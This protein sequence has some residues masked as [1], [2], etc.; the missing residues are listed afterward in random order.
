MSDS[1]N[2][3]DAALLDRFLRSVT[4]RDGHIETYRFLAQSGDYAVIAATLANPRLDVVIKLAGPAAALAC[5]FDRTTAMI[6][7]IRSRTAV[8]TFKV[9]AVD[10]S[11]TH[12]PWRYLVMTAV[13]GLPWFEA[14]R[15]ADAA[16][17]REVNAALGR[18][19]GRLHAPRFSCCGEIDPLGNIVEG[20]DYQAA[21][22]DRARRR[23]A[24]P[25]HL[26]I[27]V[28]L[29]EERAALFEEIA[30]GNICHEDL[31]PHNILVH[32]Y[33]DQG[34]T[35]ALVDFDSAWIGNAESDLARLEFWSGMVGEG[36][37][38]AYGAEA[39][40]DPRYPER[41]PIYQLLWCLEYACPTQRHNE[42][43]ASLCAS[44]DIAPI[45]FS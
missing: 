13:P 40:V 35:A 28:S 10:V 9:L 15:D 4:R 3:I 32:D 38:Q 31:N 23:L 34:P 5:P 21:L 14:R 18:A 22:L 30:G 19:V 24:D 1:V 33:S 41:R 42:D 27:F 2:A 25:A 8:P 37:W 36:F 20:K 7:L 43:T 6:G 17:L 45:I 26:R 12:W 11:Y 39:S 16:R 44:L 29:M